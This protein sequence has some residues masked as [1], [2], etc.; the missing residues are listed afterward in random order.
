MACFLSFPTQT[1]TFC[2]ESNFPKPPLVNARLR[3]LPSEFCN[4]VCTRKLTWRPYYVV[5]SLMIYTTEPEPD[6]RP[7]IPY[8]RKCSYKK[9]DKG[10]AKISSVSMPVGSVYIPWICF[11]HSVRYQ[12]KRKTKPYS[13]FPIA[14]FNTK[15][16]KRLTN[17]F[18]YP[19]LRAKCEKR[20][21]F[22]FPHR[23]QLWKMRNMVNGIVYCWVAD[24]GSTICISTPNFVEIG[25]FPA[26]I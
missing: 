2:R 25:W 9:K 18:L 3:E 20:F 22:R 7:E 5:K 16:D 6:I 15:C 19:S 12:W 26:E 14:V 21:V 10:A 24:L 17:L 11:P 23:S 1:A 13:V 4:A 8:Q